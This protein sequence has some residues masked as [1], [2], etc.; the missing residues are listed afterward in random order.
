MFTYYMYDL[1]VY[2]LFIFLRHVYAMFT[3]ALASETRDA[4]GFEFSPNPSIEI[5]KNNQEMV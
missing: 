4:F 1:F 5:Q 2:F 3:V